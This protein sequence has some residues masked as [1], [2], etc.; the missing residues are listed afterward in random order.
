MAR[1]GSLEFKVERATKGILGSM[2]SG[3]GMVN[4]FS[5]YGSVMLAPHEQPLHDDDQSLWGPAC[6]HPGDPALRIEGFV[7]VA[8]GSF[9]WQSE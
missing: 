1:T 6:R 4:T 8:S 2:L 9:C 5:G 7:G 3:E